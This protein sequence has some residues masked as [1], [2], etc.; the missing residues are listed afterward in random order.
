MKFNTKQIGNS[1]V[2]VSSDGKVVVVA[3]WDGK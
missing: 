3:G 2:S 1:D